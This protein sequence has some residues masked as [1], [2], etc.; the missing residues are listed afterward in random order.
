MC[1]FI[2]SFVLKPTTVVLWLSWDC[3]N[4]NGNKLELSKLATTSSKLATTSS[5]LA[6]TSSKL[7][8]TSSKL[9][10]N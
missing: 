3:D 2:V 9:A 1:V 5:K 4:K 10:T 8:T 6:T 7:V